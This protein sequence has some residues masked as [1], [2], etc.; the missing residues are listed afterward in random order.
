MNEP[1]T[2]KKVGRDIWLSVEI[3]KEN[4][5]ELGINVQWSEIAETSQKTFGKG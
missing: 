4:K 3:I 5:A 2:K 1:E